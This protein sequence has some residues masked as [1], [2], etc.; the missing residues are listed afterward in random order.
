MKILKSFICCLLSLTCFTVIG[1]A[2]ES[3]DSLNESEITLSEINEEQV[4]KFNNL[5]IE[6]I[7]NENGQIEIIDKSTKI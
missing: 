7:S 2:K 5:W 6:C 3:T 4:Q 1:Y